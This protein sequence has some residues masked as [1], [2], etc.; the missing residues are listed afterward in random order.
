MFS[1]GPEGRAG[2][3]SYLLVSSEEEEEEEKENHRW[4]CDSSSPASYLEEPTA[5][6]VL[7]FSFLAESRLGFAP[8]STKFPVVETIRGMQRIS[9]PLGKQMI[10]ARNPK[11]AVLVGSAWVNRVY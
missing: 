3:S 11:R 6:Y 7:L 5:D 9:C 10:S 4:N 1:L 8:P 2:L